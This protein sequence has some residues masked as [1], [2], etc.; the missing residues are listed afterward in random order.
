MRQ[1]GIYSRAQ[2][3]VEA[4]EFVRGLHK[5]DRERLAIILDRERRSAIFDVLARLTEFCV[6]RD[7]RFFVDGEEIP[8]EPYGYTMFEEYV[9]LLEDGSWSELE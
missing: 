5:T 8:S 3:A 4:N 9:T 1:E 7:W 2:D 6:G